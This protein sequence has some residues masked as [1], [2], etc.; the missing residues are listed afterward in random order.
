MATAA[1]KY[2]FRVKSNLNHNNEDYAPNDTV[3]LTEKEASALS[4]DV[5]EPIVEEVDKAAKKK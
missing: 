1:Q 2:P 3:E 5:I 4:S